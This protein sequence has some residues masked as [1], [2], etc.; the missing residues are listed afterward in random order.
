LDVLE[1]LCEQ[2]EA[3]MIEE[4]RRHKGYKLLDS[5]PTLGPVR[6]SLILAI[7]KTPHRFRSKRQFWTY[8]GMSVVSS[9]SSD[10]EVVDGTIKKT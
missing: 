5:I 2:A 4:A 8:I 10:Y 1:P 6:V 3:E 7:A 9:S